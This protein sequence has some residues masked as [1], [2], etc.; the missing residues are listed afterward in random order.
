MKPL[1][2]PVVAIVD[3]A[4]YVD[5]VRTDNPPSL[6]LTYE[7][8]RERGGMAWIGLYRPD[9]SEMTSVADEFGLHPLAVEDAVTAHQRPKLE[10]YDD[11]LFVVLHPARYLDDTET[12]EFGE[13]HVFV[14]PDFVVTVRHAESPNIGRVRTRM[15][16]DPDLL[17]LG[18]EAVLYA[19]LDRMVDDYDPVVAGLENDIDEIEN[20][21]FDG[22]PDVSRRIYDL[23][24]EVI[25]FQRATHPLVKMIGQLERGSD[26]Y[27]V[28]IELQRYLRDVL[29]HTIQITE[30]ADTFRANLQNALAVQTTLVAQR[31]NDEIRAMT[32]VSISQNEQVKKISSWGAILFAP[33]L[34]GTIY[35]MNF[36][37][38]PE[39][40]WRYG[41]PAAVAAMILMAIG[42]YVIFKRQKW[43]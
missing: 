23:S 27:K 43:L 14:G 13:I 12:V 28:D 20:Q 2:C 17:R 39:L 30:Q 21:L 26:K 41:Y 8:M 31:Q 34:V 19:I 25:A 33:T 5:G 11:Q 6:D 7:V 15:Q 42:L 40:S 18:T 3:N 35:G 10:R 4:V 1:E 9:D 37:H 16:E 36:T 32:E 29:D 22:D 24:R 38:M